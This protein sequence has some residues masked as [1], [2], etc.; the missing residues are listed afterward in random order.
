M[1]NKYIGI[2]II[3]MAVL[4]FILVLSFNNALD[5]I[6]NTSCTHGDTCPMHTTLKTQEIISYSLIGLLMVV[7]AFIAFFMKDE[8][9][10]IIKHEGRKS[11][12]TPEEK[13]EKLNN[14]ED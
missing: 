11:E 3:G 9:T 6:V 13:E 5:T 14:L 1:K 2:L 12:L 4:F 8:Q 7:G 10:T